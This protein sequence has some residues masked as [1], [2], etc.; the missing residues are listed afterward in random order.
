MSLY[1]CNQVQSWDV[2]FEQSEVDDDDAGDATAMPRWK[3]RR[4][5]RLGKNSAGD[6]VWCGTWLNSSTTN[7]G[8]FTTHTDRQLETYLWVEGGRYALPK[9]AVRR[10]D[11]S[12]TAAL[13]INVSS[14]FNALAY[15]FMEPS[16]EDVLSFA[17][18][19]ATAEYKLW[20]WTGTL[21]SETAHA[22]PT[23][24]NFRYYQPKSV[25][26]ISPPVRAW[27]PHVQIGR[28][29]K[30]PMSDLALNVV[31]EA[32]EITV[33][34]SVGGVESDVQYEPY[35]DTANPGERWRDIVFVK[36]TLQFYTPLTPSPVEHVISAIYLRYSRCDGDNAIPARAF[37][38]ISGGGNVA[39]GSG[40]A[41]PDQRRKDGFNS[42]GFTR[43]WLLMPSVNEL[44][45]EREQWAFWLPD[46]GEWTPLL[47]TKAQP[48]RIANDLIFGQYYSLTGAQYWESGTDSGVQYRIVS[49]SVET[50]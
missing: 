50:D 7:N 30:Y 37:I 47:N 22:G 25:V 18:G 12:T 41:V 1:C 49:I 4:C 24:E 45:M 6:I 40:G 17:D 38:W 14:Q 10:R 3:H 9:L 27:T 26:S 8:S 46:I 48:N 15:R 43:P 2:W 39:D 5:E 21:W 44:R 32:T 20:E 33:R 31:D 28:D 19:A 36:K 35:S 23:L 13:P 16:A 34:F 42:L 11:I 29:P